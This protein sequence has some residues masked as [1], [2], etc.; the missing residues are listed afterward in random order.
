[1]NCRAARRKIEWHEGFGTQDG[2]ESWLEMPFP[3]VKDIYAR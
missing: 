2:G 1:M 3:G